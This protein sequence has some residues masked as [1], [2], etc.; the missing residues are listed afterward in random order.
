MPYILKPPK[1]IF[2]KDGTPVEIHHV[3]QSANGPFKEMHWSEHRGKGEY[4]KNHPQHNRTS[5][6][7][8]VEFNKKKRETKRQKIRV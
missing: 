5:K 8:R 4:K 6:I 1:I 7:D 3:N 2:K